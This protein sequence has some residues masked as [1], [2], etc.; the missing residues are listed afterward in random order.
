M[1]DKNLMIRY[2][3]WNMCFYL[4]C[5]F[6]IFYLKDKPSIANFNVLLVFLP[7]IFLAFST[8][9]FKVKKFK[10]FGIANFVVKVLGYVFA[11]LIFRRIAHGT[12]FW[13]C[14]ALFLICFGV[15]ISI[16]CMILAK[17]KKK[18]TLI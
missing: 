13:L 3:V 1:I 17:S 8:E 18:L 2:F 4:L 5:I 6:C 15:S 11:Q 7:L 10:I 12:G 16:C 14:L 9:I